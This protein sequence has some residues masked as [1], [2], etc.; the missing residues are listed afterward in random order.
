MMGGTSDPNRK[1][2]LREHASLT[3]VSWSILNVLCLLM[4]L[5]NPSSVFT[6]PT[7]F[8]TPM[9][10]LLHPAKWPLG[11]IL[12]FPFVKQFFHLL[13]SHLLTF[14]AFTQY[15]DFPLVSNEGACFLEQYL[16]SIQISTQANTWCILDPLYPLASWN[17]SKTAAG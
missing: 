13:P 2:C 16:L 3:T 6:L 1:C 11:P 17:I 10:T 12:S 4:D 14:P 5:V 9:L 7:A 8:I 15:Q